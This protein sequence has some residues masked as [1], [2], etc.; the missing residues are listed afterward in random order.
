MLE[1]CYGDLVEAALP[2]CTE[3]KFIN[4]GVAVCVDYCRGRP[5]EADHSTCREDQDSG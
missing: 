2:H 3:L 4:P 1:G 5:W